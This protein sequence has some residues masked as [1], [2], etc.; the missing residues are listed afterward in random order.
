[1]KP[2]LIFGAGMQAELALFN[3][4]R[5]TARRVDAFAVDAAYLQAATF[6][7]RPVLTLEEAV[8]RFP[9]R[10][11]DMFVA[12]GHTATRARRDRFLA[13]RQLGYGMPHFVHPSAVVECEHPIGA[14]TMVHAGAVV[15]PFARLGDNVI[16][17]AKAAVSHHTRVGSHSFVAPG[18]VICG[19]VEIGECC[20]I[21]ANATVRDRVKV[22]E[23]CVVG[24]CAAITHDCDAGHVYHANGRRTRNAS[25]E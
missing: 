2:L 25:V 4:T 16:L 8:H 1:M 24:M 19:D 10:S 7:G 23:D 13:A 22:G 12:I 14:N 17:M 9:P 5:H 15:M 3:F 18:A 11:H 6:A 20:F 21:G